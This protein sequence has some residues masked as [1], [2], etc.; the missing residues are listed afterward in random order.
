MK[1]V[2]R[3]SPAAV[4]NIELDFERLP[5]MGDE[6][7]RPI[8]RGKLERGYIFG[9]L[10]VRL[11]LQHA[12]QTGRRDVQ[13]P[14]AGG[15]KTLQVLGESRRLLCT[16][17]DQQSLGYD[18]RLLRPRGKSGKKRAAF[19]SVRQ[20]QTDSFQQACCLLSLERFLLVVEDFW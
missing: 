11:L 3:F 15:G 7:G 10:V 5:A 12:K 1:N 16:Q 9:E 2:R 8:V 6:E 19:L 14:P 18:Q 13:Y 17:I 20:V 4:F